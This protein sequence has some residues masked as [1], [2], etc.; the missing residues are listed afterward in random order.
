MN[1][2]EIKEQIDDSSK[3]DI[4]EIYS[5]CDSLLLARETDEGR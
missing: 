4:E 3:S 1:V 5:Y 2:D